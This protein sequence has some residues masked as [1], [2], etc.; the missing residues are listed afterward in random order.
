M[1][2]LTPEQLV[3][4]YVSI[5]IPEL[6]FEPCIEV[7]VIWTTL[8]DRFIPHSVLVLENVGS[9][10]PNTCLQRTT[11]VGLHQSVSLWYL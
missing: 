11:A 7:L 8:R 5:G 1:G 9:E 2:T 10:V 6:C 4:L 3:G